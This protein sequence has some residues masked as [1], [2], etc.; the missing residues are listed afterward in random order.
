MPETSEL[1]PATV[2][3]E[4]M[5]GKLTLRQFVTAADVVARCF[6]DSLFSCSV[7]KLTRDRQHPL[8]EKPVTPLF[9]VH[10]DAFALDQS[11]DRHS[12]VAHRARLYYLTWASPVAD[13]KL[14]IQTKKMILDEALSFTSWWPPQ[15]PL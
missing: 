15:G 7:P 4:G 3:A 11:R 2:R 13:T 9:F 8:V 1:G 14:G 12:S 5:L 10:N 6:T